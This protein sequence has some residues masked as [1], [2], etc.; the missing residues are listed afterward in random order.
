MNQKWLGIFIFLWCLPVTIHAQFLIS[1]RVVDSVTQNP[2]AFVNIRTPDGTFVATTDIDGN[3]TSKMSK[4]EPTLLLSYVGYYPKKYALNGKTTGMLIIMSRQEYD[5][6]G[7]EIYPQQNPAHTII[8]KAI[9][10]KDLNDPEKIASL[11]YNSY[12]K[13]TAEWYLD[14][15]KY[16]ISEGY[17]YKLRSDSTFLRLKKRSEENHI[18]IMESYTQRLFR[19]GQSQETVL[20]TRVSGFTDP[21]FTT[22]ATDIQPFSF[23]GDFISLTLTDVKDYIN[24]LSKGSLE[25]YNFQ[26]QD[27]LYVGADSI[28]I[29]SF[30]PFKQK[31]FNALKGVLYISS[32]RYAIQNVIAQPAEEGLWTIKIQQQ[33]AFKAG[34]HWFPVQLNFDWILPNYPSEKVGVVL[35]G[36]S[37]ISDVD[38]NT[39]VKNR[40][41]GPS[42]LVF[43]K[44]AGT[45]DENFWQKHRTDSL[46]PVESRTYVKID[47]IGK[48]NH[49]T[50]ISRL[51]DKALKGYI[52]LSVFD[53]SLEHLFNFNNQEGIR[54]GWGMYTNEKIAKWFTIGGN[55]GYGFWDKQWKYGA[56]LDFVLSKKHEFK[57]GASYSKDILAPGL[58]ELF[59]YL[60]YSYWNNYLVDNIDFVEK[61]SA[62]TSLRTFRYWQ[63]ELAGTKES[64]TPQ[65]P[66]Q[67]KQKTIETSDS[68]AFN[69]T[70]LRVGVRF[71]YKE[72][73]ID[74]FNDR[75]SLGTKYPVL[76]LSYIH[77]FKGILGGQYDFNKLEFALEK[78]F[79]TKYFGKTDINFEAGYL[80]NQ[81]PYMKLFNGKASYSSSFVLYFRNSF[82]TMR[83]DEFFYDRYLSLQL[84]QNF[85]P[86]LFHIKK[87]RPEIS[88]T[89]GILYGTLAQR[90]MHTMEVNFKVPDHGF[91]ESGVIFDNLLRLKLLNLAY[92]K[93][94]FGV[95]Y[96]YGYYAYDKE[97]KNF[98]IKF[99]F[100]LSGNK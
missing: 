13:T 99:S 90:E 16:T 46:T 24:P 75:Y 54:V 8:R 26:L 12:S 53:I 82:Q 19:N 95:F 4:P 63:F 94:G 36:L 98:A 38:F 50:Y 29:I 27:T 74:A 92:L 81:A 91:F 78:S 76:Y 88:L 10:N 21:N 48:K 44:G 37:Y 9:A 20:G 25:R 62:W 100:K 17:D 30:S 23:Y 49:F 69:F 56:K 40:D 41:L 3:F 34:Q 83:V 42:N 28:F 79:R 14:K 32:N 11:K 67:Y 51:T 93:I 87:F 52:P 96:R 1:G 72:K 61:Y 73:L 47:S 22:L 60:N 59:K 68:N 64:R 2:L 5:L 6:S 89:Q 43:E 84:R 85:G 58:T 57:L 80:W 39:T 97:L 86:Y 71:T 33:Y 35:H 55:I 66:Y 31:N 65:Y 7:V 77:G 70:E 15:T 45:R 18:M